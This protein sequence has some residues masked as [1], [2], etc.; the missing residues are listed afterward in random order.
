MPNVSSFKVVCG[1]DVSFFFFSVDFDGGLV[2]HRFLAGALYGALGLYPT[3]AWGIGGY[4]GV[5]QHFLVV[6]LK[7]CAHVFCAAV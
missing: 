2:H 6:C 1:A 5:T 3:V 7:Y 4:V